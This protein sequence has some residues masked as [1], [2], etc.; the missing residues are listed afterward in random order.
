DVRLEHQVE[1]SRLGEVAFAELAWMLRRAPPARALAELVG[2]VAELARPAVDERVG[3]PRDVAGRDPDLR[4]EDDRRV[5]ADDVVA[6]LD[7][8]AAPL[9]LDVAVQQDAVVAEVERRPESAV[10]V[11]R[12]EDEGTPPGEGRDL[13]D[14]RGALKLPELARRH[15]L[16]SYRT[17]SG[18][19]DV[20]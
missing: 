19:R 9:G 5:E 4:V 3:E 8:R 2:A 17:S 10:D 18:L 16:G 20:D 15:G 11:R 12:R 14:R 13:L 1:L 7:H 6:L